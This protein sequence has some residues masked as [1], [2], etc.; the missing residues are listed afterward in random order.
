VPDSAR[1]RARFDAV[2]EQ[3]ARTMSTV[4]PASPNGWWRLD[5]YAARCVNSVLVAT[6]I[7]VPAARSAARDTGW[8]C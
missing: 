3:H 8:P 1:M 2:L 5:R 7:A 4:A 6:R